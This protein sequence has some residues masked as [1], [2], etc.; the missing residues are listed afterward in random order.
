MS[1]AKRPVLCLYGCGKEFSASEVTAHVASGECRAVKFSCPLCDCETKFTQF[2]LGDHRLKC[3]GNVGKLKS[4][5]SFLVAEPPVSSKLSFKHD[6]MLGIG[7]SKLDVSAAAAL[8]L[9]AKTSSASDA[10]SFDFDAPP[11]TAVLNVSAG[12]STDM[13]SKPLLSPT[14]TKDIH[15][16]RK[17]KLPPL[18]STP[19]ESTLSIGTRAHFCL[20]ACSVVLLI[21]MLVFNEQE[22]PGQVLQLRRKRQD[23]PNQNCH[24]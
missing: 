4:L 5:G 1:S 24:Q 15:V 3:S 2:E 6:G 10:R 7:E 11:A 13:E 19:A 17:L 20:S 23:L 14:A 18:S 9:E 16:S 22:L 12:M 21:S 8:A